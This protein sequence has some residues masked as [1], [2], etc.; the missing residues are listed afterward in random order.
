MREKSD[1]FCSQK[2]VSVAPWDN[3]QLTESVSLISTYSLFRLVDPGPQI[4]LDW[5]SPVTWCN[6][7][8]SPHPTGALWVPSVKLR[9]SQGRQSWEDR[10]RRTEIFIWWMCR[11]RLWLLLVHCHKS[12]DKGGPC[13][14]QSL[15][16]GPELGSGPYGKAW[17]RMETRQGWER[18]KRWA[19]RHGRTNAG[20]VRGRE[21][22]AGRC[23][24]MISPSPFSVLCIDGRASIRIRTKLLLVVTLGVWGAHLEN[25]LSIFRLPDYSIISMNY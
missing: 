3:A 13:C 1:I 23:E 20:S 4:H 25:L 21:H 17:H 24:Q 6:D 19:G 10:S 16:P 2:R 15:S 12:G 18:M 14:G 8:T 22:E 11:E 9:N 5:L 7:G